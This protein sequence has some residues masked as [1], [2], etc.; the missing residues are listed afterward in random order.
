VATV[1]RLEIERVFRSEYGRAVAVLARVFSDIDIAEDAVQEAFATAVSRWP[2]RGMPPAPAGWIITTAR[3]RAIDRLRREAS[4][5]D[6]H[7]QAALLH[8]GEKPVDDGPVQDDRLRLIFTCCHP[9]LGRAAQVALT[10]RLLGGLRTPEIARAFLV[11]ESTMAQRLV[12][13]KGKIRDAR[14]PYRVPSE[15]DMPERLASVLA[16]VYLIFNEGYAASSGDLLIRDE[17]AAEAIRLG[18]LLAE[19]MPD[20]PEVLGLLALMLLMH[21]RRPARTTEE[22]ELVPLPEQDRSLWDDDLIE[23]GHGLV[24]RCLKQNQ[25]APYQLQAAINAVH[26]DAPTASE[27]DWNQILVL[28]D[29][30][31]GLTPTAIV[32]LNR[33]VAVAEVHGPRKAL[34]LIDGLP[35]AGYYLYHAIRADVLRRLSQ[36][37][38]A[39]AAYQAAIDRTDNAAEI[40]FLKRRIA[41]I[42]T[43]STPNNEAS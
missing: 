38:E 3:N 37:H 4:R 27:T 24:K 43:Q 39:T 2:E 12:R 30:L 1:A 7:A 29:Q 19:L 15:A 23:E 41:A 21:S 33:A 8:A 13:A 34:E 42:R 35:L 25:P 9:A 10:L 36:P 26:S 28:Y 6:R 16:V 31:L 32:A 11:P 17:L 40:R 18:R 20:E 22:G 5:N 14:I